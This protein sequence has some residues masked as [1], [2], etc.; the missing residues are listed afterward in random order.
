MK[1]TWIVKISIQFEG[2]KCCIQFMQ[3][4]YSGDV[5]LISS[6][7][8]SEKHNDLHTLGLAFTDKKC[9]TRCLKFLNCRF[10]TYVKFP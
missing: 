2:F 3:I 5:C 9:H 4:P 8:N 1:G 10:L 6:S 7:Y